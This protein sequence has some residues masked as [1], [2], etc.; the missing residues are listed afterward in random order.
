VTHESEFGA[1]NNAPLE[2]DHLGALLSAYVDEQLVAADAERVESHLAVCGQCAAAVLEIREVRGLLATPPIVTPSP[3]LLNQLAAIEEAQALQQDR[4]PE[5]KQT[6]TGRVLVMAFGLAASIALLA[7]VGSY[8]LPDVSENVAQRAQS[9]LLGQRSTTPRIMAA[10]N[11]A[12]SES[13]LEPELRR[14]EER[15]ADLAILS[16][17]PDPAR[18]ETE[19]ILTVDASQVVVRERRGKLPLGDSAFGKPV[20]IAGYEVQVIEQAPFT[21]VWQRGDQ[22]ISVA[23]D[24]PHD[25]IALIIESFPPAPVD[26]GIGARVMRGVHKVRQVIG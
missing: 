4:A 11:S 14:L 13:K 1:D 15:T 22:V 12:E 2:N 8:D 17:A 7:V 6:W 16:I 24:A 20:Q 21:A 25:T 9:S 10:V 26:E 3:A 18:D 23:A 19:A 5:K